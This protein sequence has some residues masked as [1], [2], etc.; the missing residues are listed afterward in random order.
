MAV[1]ASGCSGSSA[2]KPALVSARGYPLGDLTLSHGG[3][4]ALAL[5]V[6]I[7][8]NKAAWEKGLMGVRDLP[9]DQGMAFVFPGQVSLGFWMKDTLIPLDIAFADAQGTVV[10]VQHMPPCSADPCPVYYS[11]SPY[12]TALEARSGALTAAG[13][14][15]GDAMVLHRRAPAAASHSG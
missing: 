13:I 4:R 3:H 5:T 7:A 6:E 12:S 11:A 14:H 1:A 2:P 10:D 9:A 8:D 15:A